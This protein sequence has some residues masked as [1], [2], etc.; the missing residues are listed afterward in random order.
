MRLLVA[1][2]I[3][4]KS[5]IEGYSENQCALGRGACPDQIDQRNMFDRT[6]IRRD[7]AGKRGDRRRTEP[8]PG[9]I[10]PTGQAALDWRGLF[11]LCGGSSSVG[12]GKCPRR[13]A[14]RS[15]AFVAALSQPTAALFVHFH[16]TAPT[17]AIE[18]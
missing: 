17:P 8:S 11:R 6:G 9:A 2:S 4:I 10:A 13:R 5:A 3:G 18:Q 1:G 7:P 14:S 12:P 15:A 16:A